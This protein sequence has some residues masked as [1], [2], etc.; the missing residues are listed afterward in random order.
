MCI[1]KTD[2]PVNFCCLLVQS[3]KYCTFS[4]GRLCGNT[5]DSEQAGYFDLFGIF[6]LSYF[7]LNT[8]VYT[9]A[10]YSLTVAKVHLYHSGDSQR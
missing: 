5:V 6:C 1:L 2:N 4:N 9:F 3:H 7:S 10:K 8:I